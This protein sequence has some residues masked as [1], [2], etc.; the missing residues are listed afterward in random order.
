VG[1]ATVSLFLARIRALAEHQQLGQEE[2]DFSRSHRFNLFEWFVLYDANFNFHAEHHLY[3]NTQS[4]KLKSLAMELRQNGT[5]NIPLSN[6]MVG[7]L[8]MLYKKLP[9]RL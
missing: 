6:S 5:I 4:R 1:L 7:T 8:K 9:S 2:T 3:P